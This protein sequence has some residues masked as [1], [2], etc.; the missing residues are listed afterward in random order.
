MRRAPATSRQRRDEYRR[1]LP[2][3]PRTV[4]E[5]DEEIL[6]G[7]AAMRAITDEMNER[8]G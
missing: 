1:S 8:Y 3:D 2:P 4:E 6:T 5:L 7:L